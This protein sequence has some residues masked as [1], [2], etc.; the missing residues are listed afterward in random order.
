MDE[1]LWRL[2]RVESDAVGDVS[3]SPLARGRRQAVIRER[4]VR[5]ALCRSIHARH[6]FCFQ[7]LQALA[8]WPYCS[9]HECRTYLFAVTEY[10]VNRVAGGRVHRSPD[11][12]QTPCI[13]L[14]IVPLASDSTCPV[15]F[16]IFR[17]T[18]VSKLRAAAGQGYGLNPTMLMIS[19]VSTASPFGARNV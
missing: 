8:P 11:G 18:F 14:L 9:S 16:E 2:R 15:C 12:R 10:P 17:W 1:G 4:D 3:A 13:G 6:P 5:S 7:I 19:C